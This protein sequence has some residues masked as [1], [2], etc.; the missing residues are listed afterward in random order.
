MAN[1]DGWVIAHRPWEVVVALDILKC[2]DQQVTEYLAEQME[3]ARVNKWVPDRIQ[4]LAAFTEMISSRLQ[5]RHRIT[6]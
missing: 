6:D 3:L 1:D 5:D 2:K 4:Q